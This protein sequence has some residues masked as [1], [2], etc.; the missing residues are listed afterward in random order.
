MGI[1]QC[2]AMISLAAEGYYD[3]AWCCAE[4]LTCRQ[5]E[6]I[7]VQLWYEHALDGESGRNVYAKGLLIRSLKLLEEWNF[8]MIGR[9]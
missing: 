4:V 1:A 9:S 8:E 6:V 2:D 3:R 7:R 5:P